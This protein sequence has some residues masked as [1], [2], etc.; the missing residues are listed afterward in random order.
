MKNLNSKVAVVTGA[1]SGIGRAVAIK[2]AEKGCSVALVDIDSDAMTETAELIQQ[3]GVCVST[4]IVD[5]ANRERFYE[6]AGE[7]IQEHGQVDIVVNNAGVNVA[8]EMHSISYENIEWVVG[9][10]LWGVIHGTKAF[11]PHMISRKQGHIVNISSIGGYISSPFMGPYGMTKFAVRS[12]SETLRGELKGT[13]VCVTSVHPGGIR[14]N[15]AKNT[16]FGHTLAQQQ[17]AI[18]G[19]LESTFSTS[20][21]RAATKI[22]RAIQKERFRLFIGVDSYLMYFLERLCPVLTLRIMA[23][24]SNKVYGI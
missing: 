20:P 24:V 1:A 23:R 16:R 8:E 22:V 17:E 11:L 12:L 10:N 5:V 21:E 7:V 15:I 3:S 19:K 2:L 18:T 9:I 4:H 13:G 6:F 14:T